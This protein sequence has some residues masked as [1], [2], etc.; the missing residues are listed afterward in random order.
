MVICDCGVRLYLVAGPRPS[1][2]IIPLV[3]ASASSL[4]IVLSLGGLVIPSVISPL[5]DRG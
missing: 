1:T 4:F 2:S 5:F 3:M